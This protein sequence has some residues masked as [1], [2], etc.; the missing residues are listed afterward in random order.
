MTQEPS[1]GAW[2]SYV[3]QQAGTYTN[4]NGRYTAKAFYNNTIYY[5]NQNGGRGSTVGLS[6]NHMYVIQI[7]KA[8]NGVVLGHAVQDNNYQSQDNVV[9]PAF[10]IASQLGAVLPFDQNSGAAD[11]AT[12][13]HTYMEVTA[14]G[15]RFINWRLPTPA[16]IAYIVGYQNNT[17]ISGAGVFEDVITGADYYT[18]NGLRTSTG[19][20]EGSRY[21]RCV[22]DL[23]PAEVA[24]L[25]STGTITSATY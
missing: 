25:N 17:Q 21:V 23:T 4:Y 7:S 10:M 1:T 19:Y 20:S 13:C 3:P 15:R 5:L 12:H 22:R 16:E 2:V 8:E 9:S 24:E 11:A 18:L 6:N 14:D